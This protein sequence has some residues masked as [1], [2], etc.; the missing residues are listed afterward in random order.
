MSRALRL[1]GVGV[2][3]LALPIAGCGGEPILSC[4]AANGIEP[5]CGL[6][7][8]EDLAPLPEYAHAML[9]SQF[10]SMDGSKHGSILSW[11]SKT[12]IYR[13]LFP[14]H[15]SRDVQDPE[16][17]FWDHWKGEKWGDA[18]CPGPPPPEF[19]PHGIDLTVRPDG[20]AMLLIVNH[21]GRESIEFVHVIVAG[22][23]SGAIWRG[24]VVAPDD[25]QFNDVVALPDGGF[26]VTRMMSRT[27]SQ[28]GQMIR[29]IFG[30]TT[31]WVWEWQ[32]GEGMKK[33]AGTE[34][35]MPN[36]IE[37]SPDGEE[38]YVN[39][40]AAGEVRRI[41]RR[42]GELLGTAEIASPDN[43]TWDEA[44][45]RLLVASHV[46][47]ALS[48]AGIERGS[49]PTGFEIVALDPETMETEV[50]YANRGAPMGAVTVAVQR[51]D[52]LFL[53]TF[54]GDRIGRL[55]LRPTE[56]DAADSSE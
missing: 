29:A 49:C 3:L 54:A 18:D 42:T 20:R 31:G 7:N 38:I 43:I 37:I 6:T 28:V 15:G 53:G 33:V 26:L 17:M 21:G 22:G 52:E 48:C 25:S 45:E 55:S 11:D 24:C 40:Y 46:D 36:G 23:Y 14:P 39:M 47:L 41:S 1:L 10:G 27:E 8:P 30:G 32:P 13:T 51:G 4:E 19:S 16:G 12:G 35:A 5:V 44:G 2:A 9:V 56:E 34:G 50:L